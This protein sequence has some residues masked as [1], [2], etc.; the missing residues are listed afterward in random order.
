[1]T[2]LISE[3]ID[4]KKFVVYTFVLEAFYKVIVSKK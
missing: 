3:K 4:P 1:M 2:F